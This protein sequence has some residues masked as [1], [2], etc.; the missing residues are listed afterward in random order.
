MRQHRKI[1]SALL[2]AAVTLSAV[3]FTP[4]WAAAEDTAEVAEAEL[5]E[6]RYLDVDP[7]AWYSEAVYFCRERGLMNGVSLEVEQFDPDASMNRAMLATVLYRME[8]SPEVTGENPF[9]DVVSDIW[10]GPAVIWAA[11]RGIVE[12]DGD[13]TYRPGDY[14]T[15]EE[16]ATILWRYDGSL[17]P[18]GAAEDYLDEGEISG[19]AAEAV[20]WSAERGI[21]LCLDPNYFNPG[22][23]ALRCELAHALM[24]YVNYQE[25]K[26]WDEF[27]S[28]MGYRPAVGEAVMGS[29]DMT[30][31]AADER[32][33]MTYAG[34][35]AGHLGID[36]SSHQKE[37][38]WRQVA[39]A[40]MEFA[41]IRVGYRGY[42]AGTLN[43][44][45]Y[46]R[47]NIEGALAAGLKVGVYFF[48]QAIT[49]A[50]ALEEAAYTLQLIQGY[51]ITFPVVF[52]WE[53][54]DTSTSRTRGVNGQV[55]TACA[56]AFCE[57]VKG[58]GYTPMFYASPKMAS[59]L[60]MGYFADYPFWLPHYT[61]NMTPTTYEY[62]FDIWQYT[63]KGSVPG[64]KG[65]VDIN[66]CM[67]DW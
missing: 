41:I 25:G 4:A 5:T 22:A 15:R 46:F 6:N 26:I 12:G 52:D 47:Q 48:S 29:Y 56:I 21:L 36:V 53:E 66:I 43:E 8:G 2:A 28:L 51:D 13:G 9:T 62:H 63:S 44:D 57:T 31:F 24:S 18:D 17:R 11:E 32:G 35:A 10:Y 59:G 27:E 20:D 7:T 42:T 58:A 49:V 60:D 37:I 61:K 1:L 54:Q 23:D 45:L 39:D 65:N 67:W 33:Y 40:G 30:L 3:S 64:V 50:E 34:G 55:I 14:V 38:D 19:W 16:L